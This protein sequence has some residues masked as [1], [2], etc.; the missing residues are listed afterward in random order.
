MKESSTV[1]AELP[2][3]TE[4]ETSQRPANAEPSMN[5]AVRGITIDFSEESINA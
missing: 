3:S 4:T 2:V 5:S 1:N